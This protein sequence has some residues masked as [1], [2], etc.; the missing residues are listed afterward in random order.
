M[1]RRNPNK[2]TIV[3]GAMRKHLP[4]TPSHTGS[5]LAGSYYAYPPAEG[6]PGG[7]PEQNGWKPAK[8]R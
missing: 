5:G 3:R 8:G 1:A 7:M 4:G 6:W 2:H